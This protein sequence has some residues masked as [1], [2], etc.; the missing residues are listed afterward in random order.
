[1]SLAGAESGSSN[2]GPAAAGASLL[3]DLVDGASVGDVASAM[4]GADGPDS[5]QSTGLDNPQS[6]GW[7]K[8]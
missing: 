5:A 8:R 4:G 1:M 7:T 6:P 3:E 2:A